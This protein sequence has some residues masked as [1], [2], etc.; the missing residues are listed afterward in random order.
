ME[1][2]SIN[3]KNTKRNAAIILV[4]VI[5]AAYPSIVFLNQSYNQSWNIHP[6]L[7]GFDAKE[8]AYPITIDPAANVGIP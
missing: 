5:I 6:S 2:L 3:Q 8:N 7:L 4:L 1:L